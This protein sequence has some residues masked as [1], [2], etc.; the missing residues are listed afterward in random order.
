MDTRELLSSITFGQRVAEEEID[1]LASY[2]VETEHWKRIN[3]GAIDIVYGPKGSGKSALYSL[4]IARADE[5]LSRNVIL[6]PAENPR[7]APA[8]RDL[9][10][11]P[12]ISE[13]EFAGLWKLYFVSLLCG[14]FDDHGIKGTEAA[15]IENALDQAGLIRGKKSLQGVLKAV[16]EY[17]RAAF[18]PQSLEAGVELDPAS[19]LPKGLKGKITFQEPSATGID[20][21]LLSVDHLLTLAN[22]ALCSNSN[23]SVWILLDRLD[24]A[25]AENAELEQNALRALFRV[26]LDVLGLS[27]IRLK[28]FLRTD[29]WTRLTSGGFREASHITRDMTIEWNRNSLL[30][31]VVRRA[32]HNK[33][34]QEYYG[35]DPKAVLQS[36]ASQ[37][38]LF[39]RMCPDKVDV[40]QRKPRTLD[41]ILSRT[42]DGT[43]K[44][45]PRELIHLLSSLRE[46]QIRKL[47]IG[48]REP[49]NHRLFVRTAFKDA[50]PEVSRVRLEQTLYAE[51]PSMRDRLE[52]LRGTK[53]EHNLNSLS[54]TWSL[55]MEETNTLAQ[56]L[57]DIGFFE[58]RGARESPQYWIP[59]LYRDALDLIQGSAE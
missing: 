42:Q 2:F 19:Q 37:E 6:V 54:E 10:V 38:D 12:P 8:F 46:Q 41:W 14:V 20:A 13:R 9:V 30:N 1:V 16:W 21:G 5:F 31:L 22:N 33:L 3:S 48:D 7:G 45:A 17:A 15:Q 57:T 28:I 36:T 11:D 50:L 55:N 4:L 51:Y 25:F 47:E 23:F 35:V 52:Q 24:V 43:R 39:Y 59:F 27:N 56:Q 44:N 58:R 53:T 18:R 34:L 40:G 49:E 29:I 26:Y 32:I